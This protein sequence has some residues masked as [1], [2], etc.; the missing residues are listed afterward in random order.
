MIVP[1]VRSLENHPRLFQQVG[2]HGGAANMKLF[3]ELQLDE[4]SKTRTVV[5][6]SR[7][8][9]AYGLLKKLVVIRKQFKKKYK[10]DNKKLITAQYINYNYIHLLLLII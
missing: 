3:V 2:S 1:F 10:H 7:F 9:I 4:F 8:G 6:A 5:V